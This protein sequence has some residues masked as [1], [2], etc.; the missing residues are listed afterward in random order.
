MKNE[1]R[2]NRIYSDYFSAC[3]T[4]SIFL[5]LHGRRWNPFSKPRQRWS[6]KPK[7][8]LIADHS[9]ADSRQFFFLS[10]RHTRPSLGVSKETLPRFETLWRCHWPNSCNEPT[11]SLM[12]CCIC[13]FNRSEWEG[14]FGEKSKKGTRC[15][16]SA[17]SRSYVLLYK[18]LTAN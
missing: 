12:C 15:P 5:A 3:C 1:N 14:G 17:R 9:S 10:C 2:T 6:V 18:F 13:I 4:G 7:S 11:S 16:L 8:F